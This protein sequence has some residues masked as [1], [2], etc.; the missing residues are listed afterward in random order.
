MVLRRLSALCRLVGSTFIPKASCV[1][2]V[3]I[4]PGVRNGSS[5][6]VYSHT[7][8]T[9]RY[10]PKGSL[11]RNTSSHE[12]ATVTNAAL[13]R[14]GSRTSTAKHDTPCQDKSNKLTLLPRR[15]HLLWGPRMGRRIEILVAVELF[16]VQ[17][18][19]YSQPVLITTEVVHYTTKKISG[20]HGEH[21]RDHLIAAILPVVHT[22]TTQSRRQ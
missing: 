17:L 14:A 16:L 5:H 9:R 12:F 2:K 4:G 11:D 1:N 18:N 22:C 20:L 19:G 21:L 6:V 3:R 15:I 8:S 10:E 13:I 7:G